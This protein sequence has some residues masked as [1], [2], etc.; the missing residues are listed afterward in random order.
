VA[1][2]PLGRFLPVGGV[3]NVPWRSGLTVPADDLRVREDGREDWR[4]LVT[5]DISS[6]LSGGCM[7][8]CSVVECRGN[9]KSKESG[10]VENR[11]EFRYSLPTGDSRFRI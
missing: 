4:S 5:A 2:I 11:P 9:G 10:I 6:S 3:D 8:S 1:P 7:E